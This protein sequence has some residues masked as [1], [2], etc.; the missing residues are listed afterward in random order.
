VCAIR[1]E[2]RS[3][4]CFRNYPAA[5][6]ADLEPKI[7]EAARATSA[8]TTFFDPVTIGKYGQSFVDGG[9]GQNNPIQTAFDEAKTKFPTRDI[10]CIVS[11]GAGRGALTGFGD[12][13]K[14]VGQTLIDI[15]TDTDNT[16]ALFANT[17]PEYDKEGA[18][19]RLFRFQVQAGLESVGMAEH[20]KIKEI[21]AATQ[22]YMEQNDQLGCKQLQ[23]FKAL[24]AATSE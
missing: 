18:E 9:A 6:K 14:Q 17:H 8:A 15:A 1:K 2:K 10:E 5:G 3:L 22:I 13:L 11:I 20:E 24:M 19:K 4:I 21:A 12:N 23:L 7:W 16:A